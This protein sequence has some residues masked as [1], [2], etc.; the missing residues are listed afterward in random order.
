MIGHIIVYLLLLLVLFVFNVIN[1]SYVPFLLDVIFAVLSATGLAVLGVLYFNASVRFEEENA[2]SE[3]TSRYPVRL[4]IENK[5]FIPLTRCQVIIYLISGNTDK[6]RKVRIKASCSGKS[7]QVC[8]F[9]AGC[10]DCEIVT[11][12]IKGF[13]IFDFM[14]MFCFR[15]KAE[16]SSMLIVMPKLPDIDV[17][18]KMSYVI[19]DDENMIYS[20]KKPGDDP[21]EIFAIR[22]YAGGDKIRNIHWKLSSKR[23]GLMVKDYSLPI[24]ENDYVVIDLF[25][26]EQDIGA[27]DLKENLNQVFDLFYGLINALTK[28]GYGFNACF[29][30]DGYRTLRIETQNDIYYLFT[31]IYEIKPY[32]SKGECAAAVFFSE[33][34]GQKKR[35]FYVTGYLDE[36]TQGQMRLLSETGIVYYLIPGYVNNSYMP[37]KFEG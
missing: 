12:K 14:N 27:K 8:E 17:I 5:S 25:K 4:I 32:D 15:K 31:Q 23:D 24:R 18:Q 35:V 34:D 30:K 22:E 11:M 6:K 33:H 37:V 1:T 19:S 16:S 26:P 20:D 10:D 36:N 28:R 3:R 21:T 13:Y 9:Y 7:K 2:V 29:Y